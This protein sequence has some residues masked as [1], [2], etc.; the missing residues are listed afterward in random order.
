[1]I[2]ISII[3]KV[4]V[5]LSQANSLKYLDPNIFE[6]IDRF[7]EIAEINFNEYFLEYI[8]TLPKLDF[9]NVVKISREVYQ[10]YG[11]ETE[12]D[13][14]LEKLVSN[15]NI[16][17]GSLNKEDENCITN[18]SENRILLSGTCYD[19]IMLC[20]EIG[21][22]LRYNDSYNDKIMDS[23][24]FETP[25]IIMEFAADEYLKNIYNIDLGIHDLRKKQI[26][27]RSKDNNIENDIFMIII[28]LM[29]NNKLDIIHLYNGIVSNNNIS[30][31]LNNHNVSIMESFDEAMSNY[32]YEIGYII[33]SNALNSTNKKELLDECLSYKDL[34]INIPFTI[35]E[36]IIQT[37]LKSEEHIK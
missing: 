13:T 32:N 7:K 37:S 26:L 2:N 25:S 15:H 21:H 8:S 12:F 23:V 29:K 14:I 5:F 28:N 6:K 24:L 17:N 4:R 34:G 22:K 31:Y 11:K 20:H 3:K 10:V 16:D 30:N 36:N 9:E 35:D 1:M 33:G 19:V 18:A 27:S